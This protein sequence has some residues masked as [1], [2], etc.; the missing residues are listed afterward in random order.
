LFPS[1]VRGEGGPKLG[2][3][4]FDRVRVDTQLGLAGSPSICSAG[5]EDKHVERLKATLYFDVVKRCASGPGPVQFGY[6]LG[7]VA[8]SIPSA[9]P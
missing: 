3:G 1:L 7:T 5:H 6:A 9:T 4:D 2:P 8:P